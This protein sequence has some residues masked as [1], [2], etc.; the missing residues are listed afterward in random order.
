MMYPF[1]KKLQDKSLDMNSCN[2]GLWYNKFIPVDDRTFKACDDRGI[3]DNAITFYEDYYKRIKS[4][5]DIVNKLADKHCNQAAFCDS[6]S[7]RYEKIVFK[8]ELKTPLITG[9]GES[10]PHEISMVFDRNIGIPYIPASGIKGIV[11]FCH[12]LGLIPD[13]P[14]DKLKKDKDGNLYFDDEESWTMV[15]DLFGT[16]SQRGSVI[17]LDGYPEKIPDLH[18]DIMNPHY[19]KYYSEGQPPGDYLDPVPLKFLTV[20]KGTVFVF[21]VLIERNKSELADK[22]K[23]AFMKIFTEEGIGAKT[24]VGYGR[25]D[26]VKEE[27]SGAVIEFIKKEDKIKRDL[28][29]EAE[30]KAENERK[31]S[32]GPDDLMLEEISN[33]KNDTDDISKIVKNIFEAEY[34]K[35]VYQTLKSKLEELGQWKPD[36]SKQKK[37]KMKTRNEKIDMKI[38][39]K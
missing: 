3:P 36:G 5:A 39:Q 11:R 10:H 12:I 14:D 30:D 29:K 22:I 25:F 24:A 17:F 7:C 38:S 21:R 35:S 27:E 18:V 28:L 8:A 26:K 13:I 1:H 34:G 23:T 15:P 32:M 6:F 4:S 2:F 16:Q 33:L 19:V 9:T 31:A 37:E 20:S